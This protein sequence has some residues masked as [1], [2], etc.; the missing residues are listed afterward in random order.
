MTDPTHDDTKEVAPA[1]YAEGPDGTPVRIHDDQGGD[2]HLHDI[3]EFFALGEA[4]TTV[5]GWPAL[6]LT[7][8]EVRRLKTA[9]D[10]YSFD[11]DEGLIALCLDIH[12]YAGQQPQPR[13]WLWQTF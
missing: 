6:A 1:V 5:D 7:E 13:Y 3:V 8:A 12:R 10:A 4:G 2:Y 9:A 11:H